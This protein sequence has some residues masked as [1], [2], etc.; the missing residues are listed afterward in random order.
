MRKRHSHT[1]VRLCFV[2]DAHSD[3]GVRRAN[4][5][6]GSSLGSLSKKCTRSDFVNCPF[7]HLSRLVC[8]PA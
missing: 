4:R 8:M 6:G 1:K 5:L 3:F 2:G 7:L